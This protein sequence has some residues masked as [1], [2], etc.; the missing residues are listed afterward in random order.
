MKIFILRR[1]LLGL[2]ISF[3]GA[4]VIYTV[5]RSLPTSYVE[6]I[7]RERASNPLSTKTYQEWLDQLN[8]IYRLNVGI[9]PGFSDGSETLSRGISGNPALRH[10]C[11]R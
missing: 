8:V 9:I 5:I 4:M 2:F 6:T 7:A 3:F 10:P 11:H 1:L